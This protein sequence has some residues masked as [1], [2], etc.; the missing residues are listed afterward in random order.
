LSHVSVAQ[1]IPGA[2]KQ[3]TGTIRGFLPVNLFF[4]VGVSEPERT[5]VTS[6][7]NVI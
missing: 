2:Q 1:I 4:T 7:I 6:S 3:D 5:A